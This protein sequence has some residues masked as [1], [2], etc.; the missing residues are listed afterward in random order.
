M[1]TIRELEERLKEEKLKQKWSEI[2]T[3][4][5]EAKTKYSG[6]AFGNK[7]LR[8]S[9]LKKY[10]KSNFYINIVYIKD[11]ILDENIQTIEDL[12]RCTDY[13][14]N[15]CIKLT[16][17]SFDAYRGGDGCWSIY[18]NTDIKWRVRDMMSLPY[19]ISIETYE[20]VKTLITNSIDLIFVTPIKEIEFQSSLAKRN[21]IELLKENGCK[22]IE[23]TDSEAYE[24]KDHP[25]LYGNELL[26]ND[27][28]KK[29]IEDWKKEEERLDNL[30]VGFYCCG[31]YVRPSGIHKRALENINSILKKFKE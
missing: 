6:K 11:I 28:S 25:F 1:D 21:N 14:T 15:D 9:C 8:F 4:L 23:L 17:D 7:S 13:D 29:I 20:K 18:T 22:I 24:I 30:D 26:V 10:I 5:K 27:L 19:E 16:V 2:Q 12:K 31:E 3:K